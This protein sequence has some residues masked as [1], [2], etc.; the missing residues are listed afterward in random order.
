[1]NSEN[2]KR[3]TVAIQEA[4]RNVKAWI[5][6][7]DKL[8]T[9]VSEPDRDE[10]SLL[11]ILESHLRAVS[12]TCLDMVSRLKGDAKS[13]SESLIS[14]QNSLG[15]L[16]SP[17]TFPLRRQMITIERDDFQVPNHEDLKLTLDE[18][19]DFNLSEE[20]SDVDYQSQPV[21]FAN[22]TGNFQY[23][24]QSYQQTPNNEGSQPVR[25]SMDSQLELVFK[26]VGFLEDLVISQS[27]EIEDLRNTCQRAD[28]YILEM[29]ARFSSIIESIL[30]DKQKKSNGPRFDQNGADSDKVQETSPKDSQGQAINKKQQRVNQVEVDESFLREIDL[31]KPVSAAYFSKRKRT[32]RSEFLDIFLFNNRRG[33]PDA[34]YKFNAVLDHRTT[35]KQQKID[36]SQLPF[37][38]DL[39]K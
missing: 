11:P 37:N 5:Q 34:N 36:S 13:L 4:F 12:E 38:P 29:D 22:N 23:Y 25:E 21:S 3:I 8:L 35:K 16:Q 20:E 39:Q 27:K 14:L 30:K 18:E 19:H 9:K 32:G 24:E 26:K 1:M 10:I 33:D 7:V 17:V 28:Q 15:Q 6:K 31:I 2:P